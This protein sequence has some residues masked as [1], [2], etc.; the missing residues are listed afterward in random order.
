MKIEFVQVGALIAV[1][2]FLAAY[3]MEVSGVPEPRPIIPRDMLRGRR[4]VIYPGRGATDL[5]SAVWGAN[6]PAKIRRTISGGEPKH[7]RNPV[8]RTSRPEQIHPG[9][10]AADL[11]ATEDPAANLTAN[12]TQQ[13]NIA[14]LCTPLERKDS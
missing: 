5:L 4:F 2:F 10:E 14:D 12:Q 7:Q 13:P 9:N 3:P 6:G 11:G 1:L 8:T